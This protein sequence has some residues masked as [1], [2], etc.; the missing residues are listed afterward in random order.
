MGRTLQVIERWTRFSAFLLPVVV[1]V[2]MV[3]L[4]TDVPAPLIWAA[5]TIAAA[6]LVGV[7][8]LTAVAL[9][10]WVGVFGIMV[11]GLA[12]WV[13]GPTALVLAGLG[14]GLVAGAVV[15]L[16]LVRSAREREARIDALPE[17]NRDELGEVADLLSEDFERAG[18]SAVIGSRR[19][20]AVE[21]LEAVCRP[22]DGAT[23]LA[24][25]PAIAVYGSRV[26]VIGEGDLPELPRG[27][28]VRRFDPDPIEVQLLA[29]DLALHLSG[30]AP[31][32]GDAWRGRPA[33]L[34]HL[35]LQALSG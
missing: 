23:V 28:K 8:V 14:V 26:A 31:A 1:V 32:N 6:W 25:D 34:H 12:V 30:G 11:A 3:A 13:G 22:L 9:G 33:H 29:H 7:G 10:A 24:Q 18:M 20:P 2:F 21:L 4:L 17:W 16:L 35:T 19:D 15:K 5:A 27:A